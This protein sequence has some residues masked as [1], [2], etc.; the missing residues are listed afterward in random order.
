MATGRYVAI[1]FEA[2]RTDIYG[3]TRNIIDFQKEW[4]PLD[5]SCFNQYTTYAGFQV[6]WAEVPIEYLEADDVHISWAF[7]SDVCGC[8]S[9]SG[10]GKQA[11]SF[12]RSLKNRWL[13]ELVPEDS[14]LVN[15]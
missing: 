6:K 7:Q 9:F 4:Q 1:P 3:N 12:F 10:Y 11:I 13:L 15:V 2:T 14:F 5:V 8:V